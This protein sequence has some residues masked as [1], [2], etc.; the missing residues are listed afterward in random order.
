MLPVSVGRGVHQADV[1]GSQLSRD[2]VEQ[3]PKAVTR[4]R[5]RRQARVSPKDSVPR[6]E[7]HCLSFR[8]DS[9]DT[10]QGRE[11]VVELKVSGDFSHAQLEAAEPTPLE[12]SVTEVARDLQLDY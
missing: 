5:A 1:L 12:L 4:L 3:L 6:H 9:K 10:A 7:R 8:T 11:L 2:V